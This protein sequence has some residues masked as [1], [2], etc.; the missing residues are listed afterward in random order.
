MVVMVVVGDGDTG[1][2]VDEGSGIGSVGGCGSGGGGG[3]V[4][5]TSL[6][7]VSHCVLYSQ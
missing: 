1:G 7:I 6:R 2:S 3:V 5:C 4:Y